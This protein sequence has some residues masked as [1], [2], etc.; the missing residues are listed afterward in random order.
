M[1][2]DRYTVILAGGDAKRLMPLSR[3]ITGRRP[4]QS[5]PIIGKLTLQDQR[6][7]GLLQ[8][9]NP[10]THYNRAD[11]HPGDGYKRRR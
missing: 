4:K 5:C 9:I 2:Q 8:L 7:G 3:R 1:R 11:R 6:G 10:K